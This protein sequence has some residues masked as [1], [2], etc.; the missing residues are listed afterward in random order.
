[1]SKLLI[2]DTFGLIFRAYHAYPMLTTADGRPTNAIFGFMQMLLGSIE[3]FNPDGVV[4]SLES[5]SP[6]FRHKIDAN[7]KANRKSPDEELK[8][9]IGE[10]INIIGRIGIQTLFTDEYEADDVISRF[11]VCLN[12][13]HIVLL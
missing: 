9:Q 3:K 2:I 10:I 8:S 7:Y 13:P 1:M 11:P 4:C 6:T 5:E 12:T